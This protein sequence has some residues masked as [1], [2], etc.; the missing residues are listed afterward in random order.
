MLQAIAEIQRQLAH[1]YGMAPRA[2]HPDIP[3]DCPDGAY[4]M[5]FAG[6]RWDV[7][8]RDGR[9]FLEEAK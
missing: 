2:D 8:V 9:L 6:K 7:Q 4:P 1:V 3:A 5:T